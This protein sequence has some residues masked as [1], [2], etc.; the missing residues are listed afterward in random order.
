MNTE[1]NIIDLFTGTGAFSSVFLETSDKN[2]N[3]FLLMILKK[4]QKKYLK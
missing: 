1:I 3:V 2:L 4:I